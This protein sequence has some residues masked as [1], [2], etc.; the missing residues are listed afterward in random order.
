MTAK[1]KPATPLPSFDTMYAFLKARYKAERFHLRDDASWGPDYSKCVT[2]SAMET[3]KETGIGFIGRFESVTGYTV[4]YNA[5]LCE[6]GED[7]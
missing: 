3:L 2:Q 4:K 1:M 6:L 7:A 5:F